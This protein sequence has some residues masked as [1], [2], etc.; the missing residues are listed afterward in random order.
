M[1]T[2]ATFEAMLAKGQDNALLRFS[3]GHAYLSEGNP[4]QAVVHLRVAVSQ[5]NLYSAAWKLL[6]RALT[7]IGEIEES[8]EVYSRGIQVAERNGDIQAA[9][10]MRVFLRRLRQQQG[11]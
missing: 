7:E 5:D 6:A 11:S 3:L 10:E 1:S 8:I 4:Q 9:K 2:S